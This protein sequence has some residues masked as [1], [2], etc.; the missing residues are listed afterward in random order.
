MPSACVV[1]SVPSPIGQQ[2]HGWKGR[3]GREGGGETPR[4]GAPFLIMVLVTV[5]EALTRSEAGD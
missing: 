5:T 3:Q 1:H 4:E 2:T